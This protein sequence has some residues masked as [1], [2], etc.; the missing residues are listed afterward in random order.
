M[1]TENR[2]IARLSDIMQSI[3]AIESYR[4]APES[5]MRDIHAACYCFAVI[6]EAVNHLSDAVRQRYG[7]V[8][9]AQIVGLRNKLIH[10]YG[11]VDVV[12]LH[13]VVRRHLPVLKQTVL[14]M[15]K[16]LAL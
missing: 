6:G 13:E 15:Q 1:M 8:P 11:K 12:L 16:E 3:E 10:E 4:I 7:D 14:R 2:D 9:W 5:P